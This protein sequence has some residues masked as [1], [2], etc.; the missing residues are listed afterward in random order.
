MKSKIFSGSRQA[1]F[2]ACLSALEKLD[3]NVT[4]G[5]LNDG[6]ITASK[7]SQHFSYG[8][9]VK[10]SIKPEGIDNAKVKVITKSSGVSLIDWGRNATIEKAFIAVLKLILK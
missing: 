4:S 9:S 5:N 3:C 8:Y 7:A 2:N 1:I 6:I 10:I